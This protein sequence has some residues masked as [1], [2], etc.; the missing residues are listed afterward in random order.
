MF[1]PVTSSKCR[2]WRGAEP[3]KVCALGENNASKGRK[4]YTRALRGL[5][6]GADVALA[7]AFEEEDRETARSAAARACWGLAAKNSLTPPTRLWA[8]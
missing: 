2:V 1:T 7:A 3:P 8:L 5:C 4:V 6:A